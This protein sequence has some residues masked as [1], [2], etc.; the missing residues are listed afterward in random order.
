MAIFPGYAASWSRAST[1]D[2]PTLAVP[3]ELVRHHRR[4]RQQRSNQILRG[5]SKRC[6]DEPPP[7]RRPLRGRLISGRP[8]SLRAVQLLTR[9]DLV[10]KYHSGW[11]ALAFAPCSIYSSLLHPSTRPSN[12][13]SSALASTIVIG[14]V[15]GAMGPLSALRDG[16]S[17]TSAPFRRCARSASFCLW[18]PPHVWAAGISS[19]TTRPRRHPDAAGGQASTVHHRPIFV[20]HPLVMVSVTCC[21]RWGGPRISAV[22]WR[23][24]LAIARCACGG[25]AWCSWCGRRLACWKR[26]R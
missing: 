7:S 6:G 14:G 11:R 4:R 8:A 9:A 10:R 16:H 12:T 19:R 5:R 3:G 13:S 25:S 23:A 15:P 1:T 22:R 21:C 24:A 20:L 18:T 26:R 17:L 2:W